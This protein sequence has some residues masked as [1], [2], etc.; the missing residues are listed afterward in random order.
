MV[1]LW[2]AWD[3][4]LLWD[5]SVDVLVLGVIPKNLVE[6]VVRKRS[7]VFQEDFER[8]LHSV[9]RC[10]FPHKLDDEPTLWV[11]RSSF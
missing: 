11:L 7:F 1:Q 3:R 6:D 8:L 4:E 2:H 5:V 9:E 10:R